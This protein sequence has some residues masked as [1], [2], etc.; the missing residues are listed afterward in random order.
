MEHSPNNTLFELPLHSYTPQ[1]KPVCTRLHLDLCAQ[2]V[3]TSSLSPNHETYRLKRLLFCVDRRYVLHPNESSLLHVVVYQQVFPLSDPPPLGFSYF[4][5]FTMCLRSNVARFS[6]IVEISQSVFRFLFTRTRICIFVCPF[7][8]V[9]RIMPLT[10]T[11]NRKLCFFRFL[12]RFPD[13]LGCHFTPCLDF[14]STHTTSPKKIAVYHKVL[15]P[16]S[17]TASILNSWKPYNKFTTVLIHCGTL[18][19]EHLFPDRY[20]VFTATGNFS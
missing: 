14:P 11:V 2:P 16:A 20:L 3:R 5:H 4:S 12:F 7:L 9:P 15:E 19:F 1:I 8:A 6:D 17:L 10:T 18:R 13:N